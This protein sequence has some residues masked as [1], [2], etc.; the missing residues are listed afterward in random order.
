MITEIEQLVEKQRDWRKESIREA[1]LFC[2]FRKKT[3]LGREPRCRTNLS[4]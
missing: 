1:K 3:G 4:I 2:E